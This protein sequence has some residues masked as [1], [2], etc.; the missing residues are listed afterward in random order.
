M[1]FDSL[2]CYQR[3]ANCSAL[4]KALVICTSMLVVDKQHKVKSKL[5][6]L[7]L[8]EENPCNQQNNLSRFPTHS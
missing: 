4:A 8:L 1:E 7:Y 3:V 6:F 5:L 2:T